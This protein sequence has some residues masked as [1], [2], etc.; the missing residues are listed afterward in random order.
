MATIRIIGL[1]R[2]G[3]GPTPIDGHYLVKFDISNGF[4]DIVTTPFKEAATDYGTMFDACEVWR[5]AHGIRPDG[6]PDRPL[7]AY[8]VVIE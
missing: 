4:V 3:L 5:T 8:H 6:K 7:T 2:E 1:A